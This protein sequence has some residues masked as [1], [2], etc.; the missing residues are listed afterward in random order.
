MEKSLKRR[1]FLKSTAA[2]GAAAIVGNSARAAESIELAVPDAAKPIVIASANGMMATAKA[3]ELIQ[4][5]ADALDA[6]IAGVNIVEDD[7]NDNSVGYGGLPNEEGVVELDSSVM[8]G[9]TGRGGAVASIRNIKNP[10]KVAKLVMERTDH[11]LLVGEGALR[12]AKAHGFQEMD[13]LTDKS[14]E[15][16]L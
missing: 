14:R 12:F 16:W 8:H 6:V 11:V 13:L 9:P 10:S 4:Q 5:G 15:I 2:L 7:P 3:M 1:D